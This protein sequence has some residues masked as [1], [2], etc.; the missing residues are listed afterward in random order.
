MPS[1]YEIYSGYSA[2]YDEL[3]SK[4][5]YK[6]N[7]PDY[8]DKAVD[9]SGKTVVE[10]GVGTGRLTE[11]YAQKAGAV[12]CFDR[13]PHMLEKAERNLIKFDK[14]IDFGI[15][16]N[17]KIDKI[18]RNADIIIE[19]WSFGHTVS[20]DYS[21]IEI[22]TSEIIENCKKLLNPGGSIIIIE[23]LGTNTSAVDAPN[24]AL[25]QFYSLLEEKYSFKRTVLETD[26]KFDSNE[27]ALRITG[28]F[29]G[30]DFRNNLSFQHE[31]IVKEFTGAWIFNS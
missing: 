17:L 29:F 24:E 13:S 18:D 14:K 15:C 27:E 20:D 5:D 31:G 16:D 10:L 12:F 21:R 19:G 11:I 3:V 26:Y 9:F 7:I 2:E 28:F 23:S 6:R 22:V 30:D 4:E 25:K 1:M 8:L